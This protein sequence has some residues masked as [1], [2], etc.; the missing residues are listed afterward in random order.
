MGRVV[1]AHIFVGSAGAACRW[2]RGAI[3][4]LVAWADLVAAGTTDVADPVGCLTRVV[5]QTLCGLFAGALAVHADDATVIAA[6]VLDGSARVAACRAALA[7]GA[8]FTRTAR[9]A[10]GAAVLAIASGVDAQA[11]AANLIGG[12]GPRSGTGAAPARARLTIPAP[13]AT[14]STILGIGAGIDADLA[15]LDR[16]PLAGF[17]LLLLFREG[18]RPGTGGQRHGGNY[19]ANQGAARADHAGD[20]V[21][22]KV[23]HVVLQTLMGQEAH[24]ESGGCQVNAQ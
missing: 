6:T 11:A 20:G 24:S 21:K 17:F 8:R 16:A 14:S 4:D 22:S 12:T 10:A 23:V 9:D 1:I 19:G 15:A 13:G 5:A 2:G 7:T 3:A 18:L